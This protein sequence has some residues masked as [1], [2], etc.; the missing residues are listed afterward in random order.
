MPLSVCDVFMEE[1]EKPQQ[2]T[3]VAPGPLFEW[4]DK[5][6]GRLGFSKN[7]LF[8]GAP[9]SPP[10]RKKWRFGVLAGEHDLETAIA[11]NIEVQW[12][13]LSGFGST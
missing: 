3:R 5:I 1:K 9:I 6:H 13:H 7:L 12:E 10:L 8:W 4:R 11:V 2:K